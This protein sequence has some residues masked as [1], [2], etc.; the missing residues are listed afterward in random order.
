MTG[1]HGDGGRSAVQMC[2]Q[3]KSAR[4]E[5]QL[6]PFFPDRAWAGGETAPQIPG[7]EHPGFA[8]EEA[9]GLCRAGRSGEGDFT[10]C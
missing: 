8:C 5:K 7:T 6:F 9:Q 4:S 10:E 2:S 1:S 3:G